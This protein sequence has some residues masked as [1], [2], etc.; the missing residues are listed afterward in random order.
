V[1]QGA[2]QTVF[3]GNGNAFISVLNTAAATGQGLVYST[4]FG[5]S[6]GEVAYDLRQDS[7]GRF[8]IG[9]YTLSPDLPVTGNAMYGSSAGGSVDGFVAVI[10]PTQPPFSPHALV[11]STYITGPGLQV[12]YGVDVDQK[13]AVYVAGITTS[14]V[15]PN[16]IPPNNAALKT[17]VFVL[18]FTLP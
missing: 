10:D 15:F 4:Y 7:A 2:Y 16:G 8:Y 17:S 6:G 11:Y 3:G 12:V 5:G 14:N 18:I 9:G 13:G 1:T